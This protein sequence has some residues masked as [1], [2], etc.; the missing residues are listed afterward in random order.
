[1]DDVGKRFSDYILVGSY[2]V[3]RTLSWSKILK[4]EVM[5]CF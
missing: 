3:Y 5:G 4:L 2:V 1:L